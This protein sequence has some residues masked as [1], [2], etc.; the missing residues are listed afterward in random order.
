[1]NIEKITERN[2]SRASHIYALSWK[3]AYRGIVPQAYLDELSLERWTPVLA[4]S[5]RS[6]YLLCDEG[7]DVATSSI[8]AARDEQMA[9]WGEIMSLYVHPQAFRKG[10]GA[11]LFSYVTKQLKQAGFEKI[12]LWVLEE[13][14]N[15]RAFYERMGFVPNGD[16]SMISI[17]GKECVEIRYVN[18]ES[19]NR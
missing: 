5:N 15:A 6:G 17:G 18:R 4:H 12:Y 10:Y 19:R 8:S 2:A 7:R 11:F 3:S 13:N 14:V 1:M 16:R 9:G